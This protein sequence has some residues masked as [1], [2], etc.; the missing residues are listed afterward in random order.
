METELDAK[1]NI[2]ITFK[3]KE[4]LAM[5]DPRDC[6]V[7][8]SPEYYY[9]LYQLKKYGWIWHE[10]NFNNGDA[11][12]LLDFFRSGKTQFDYST[13]TLQNEQFLINYMNSVYNNPKMVRYLRF[14]S[15]YSD[16]TPRYKQTKLSAC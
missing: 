3:A 6:G 2:Y 14:G 15:V 13:P 9:N 4:C 7:E 16:G 12:T 1:Y 8:N 10:K 5:F 11:I